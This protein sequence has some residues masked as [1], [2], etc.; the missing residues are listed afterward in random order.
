MLRFH[1]VP[2]EKETRGGQVRKEVELRRLLYYCKKLIKVL[3]SI[4]KL[5]EISE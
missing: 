3:N 5:R 4:H 1:V 2:T